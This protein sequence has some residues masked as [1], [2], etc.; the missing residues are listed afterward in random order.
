M[1]GSEKTM[2]KGEPIDKLTA[3]ELFAGVGGF[4]RGLE[5]TGR[6][7]VAWSNQWEPGSRSQF[8][9]NCYVSHFTDKGHVCED[10]EKVLNYLE[11]GAPVSNELFQNVPPIPEHDLL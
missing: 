3:V 8:A 6:W 9:S 2:K 5:N 1:H 10:I 4:R 11:T 7:E